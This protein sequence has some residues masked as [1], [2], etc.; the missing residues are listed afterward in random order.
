MGK[1]GVEGEA[2]QHCPSQPRHAHGTWLWGQR[3]TQKGAV[4]ENAGHAG[5]VGNVRGLQQ[6]VQTSPVPAQ[7]NTNVSQAG[8]SHT[9]NGVGYGRQVGVWEM[10]G[11][12]RVCGQGVGRAVVAGW[13]TGKRKRAGV[14]GGR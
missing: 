13:C 4:H 11:R 10:K 5:G 3:H 6:T 12:K 9:Q 8:V 7:Q 14:C 1:G 2:Q